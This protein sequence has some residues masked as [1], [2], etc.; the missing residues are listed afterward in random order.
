MKFLIICKKDN[1]NNNLINKAFLSSCNAPTLISNEYLKEEIANFD[2]YL[3]TYHQITHEKE[4]EFYKI[5]PNEISFFNGFITTRNNNKKTEILKIFEDDD[6]NEILLGDYQLFHLDNKGNGFIKTPPASIYPIFYYEDEYCTILSNELKLIV[7]GVKTFNDPFIKHYN[8]N[9]LY[10]TYHKGFFVRGER[11]GIRDTAFKNISRILPHDEIEIKNGKIIKRINEDI[12]IPTWFEKWYLEDKES[13]Y[14]WYY[15]ELINYTNSMLDIISKNVDTIKIGLTGGYDSR[16]TLLILEKL[17]KE[18][19]IKIQTQTVG[20]PNH[21]DVVIAKKIAETLNIPWIN[22]HENETNLKILP[23]NL[24]DYAST[25]YK[26]HGD[27]DSHDFINKHYRHVENINYFTQ[28]GMDLYKRDTLTSIINFN[29]WFSRRILCSTH[30]YFPLFATTLELYFSLIY[31]K[32]YPKQNY[33][34]EFVY[35]VIKRANPKL[36]EIPFAFKSLPQVDIKEYTND[37]YTTTYHD[38]EPFLW[39]YEL[40]L[41]ELNPI[42]KKL[43]D[44]QNNKFD[45]I[46]D[47]TNITPLDY[48]LLDKEINNIL[49]KYNHNNAENTITKLNHIKDNAFYPT[50]RTYLKIDLKE[51]YY[52][53]KRGLLKLMDYA[54]VASF[55]SFDNIEHYVN[56]NAYDSKEEVYKK[57]EELSQN[58]LTLMAEK[59]MLI[60]E[61]QNLKKDKENL[62]KEYKK[63][64]SSNS[65][66]ITK[67]LRKLKN[68]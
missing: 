43:Y 30:F 31:T 2:I 56:S 20:S 4:N 34:T 64:L 3:Y 23:Q 1:F 12:Q 66:K 15:E 63:I 48:F 50:N 41:T 67:P 36:L 16:L 53:K 47:K 54:S 9:Y 58:N 28:N 38:P 42:L 44:K 57:I 35:N 18:H 55:N 51:K 32:Y 59:E 21:P 65:W 62:K 13:L 49:K 52:L 45:L 33:Y 10:E 11:E 24:R 7:D 39:D 40:V 26:S 17:C 68:R 61:N 25:F 37:T 46:L 60:E 14:D 27:F 8:I 6:K 19:N 22:K 29:R 5:K